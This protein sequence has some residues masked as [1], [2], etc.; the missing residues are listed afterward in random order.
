MQYKKVLLLVLSML[1]LIAFTGPVFAGYLEN[2]IAA[3]NMI[4]RTAFVIRVARRDVNEHRVY[5]GDLAR[6]IAHQKLAK[7]LFADGEYMRA[8][9]QTKWARH[10][11][12]KAI[13]ANKGV[14]PGEANLT[15]E[16]LS[17]TANSPSGEELDRDLHTAM[18]TEPTQDEAVLKFKSDEDIK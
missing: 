5:T 11:A 12:K 1:L 10:L 6:A 4:R 16:E 14:V 2:R 17:L 18:P 13:Y 9:H 15:T 3:K 8:M 7:K